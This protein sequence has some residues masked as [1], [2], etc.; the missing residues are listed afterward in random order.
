MKDEKIL[1]DEILSDDELDQVVGGNAEDITYDLK[2][3]YNRGLAN[4][5]YS[6][7]T[8]DFDLEHSRSSIKMVKDGFWKAGIS[9]IAHPNNANKYYMDGKEI[10]RA[11]AWAYVDQHFPKIPGRD[12]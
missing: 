9:C 11:E 5:N 10:S 3:L 4:Y 6:R 8:V 12:A 1:Q 2:F 7:Y